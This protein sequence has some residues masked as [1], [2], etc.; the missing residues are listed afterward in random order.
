MVVV[1]IVI[2]SVALDIAIVTTITRI[3]VVK[4][5]SVLAMVINRHQSVCPALKFK[6]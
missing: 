6:A 2:A 5:W 1:S 4:G 3:T